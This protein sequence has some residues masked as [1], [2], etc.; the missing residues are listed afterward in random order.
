MLS[1]IS[2]DIWSFEQALVVIPTNLEGVNGRG[3]ARQMVDRW[4][5]L[6]ISLRT[7]GKSEKMLS[8]WLSDA[9]LHVY[10]PDSSVSRHLVLFPVKMKWK[11]EASIQVITR[12]C[13]KLREVLDSTPIPNLCLMPRVGCGFGELNFS[14]V[15]PV[16]DQELGQYSDRVRLIEPTSDVFNRYPSSFKPG[17]REDRSVVKANQDDPL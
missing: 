16:L 12:S 3:L 1:K 17:F 7:Y 4:P 15:L 10:R 6:S 14:D 5:S 13:S 8:H 11:D 2:G 9:P